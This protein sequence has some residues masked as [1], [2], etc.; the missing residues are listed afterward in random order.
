[1]TAARTYRLGV[2]AALLTALLLMWII[3][4]VGLIGVEGDPFDR[5]YAGVLA[6]AIV[7]ALI[8]R[9]RPRGMARAMIAT[10]LAQTLVTVIAL[11]VG[12]QHVPVSSVPE[13]VLLNGFY[14]VLWI[15][16]AWLFRK[17]ARG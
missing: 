6:V 12:K 7:G 10:A 1:M 16:S 9:F 4:A 17:A 14:V 11:I 13:I 3:G 5:L 8:A 2:G 15:G